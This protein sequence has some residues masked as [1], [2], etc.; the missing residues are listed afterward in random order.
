[1][2]DVSTVNTALCDTVC[3]SVFTA[4]KPAVC[5]S[6]RYPKQAT[7]QSTDSGS[8]FCTVDATHCSAQCCAQHPA[9]L[10]AFKHTI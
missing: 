2:S 8:F 7:Y 9:D 5:C 10:A 3:R 6:E 4:I 1:M